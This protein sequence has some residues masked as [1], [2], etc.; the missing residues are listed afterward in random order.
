MI[1]EDVEV[2]DRSLVIVISL[3]LPEE[4]HGNEITG[5]PA[6]IRTVRLPNT[7]LH[8]YRCM[9]KLYKSSL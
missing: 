5:V 3:N 4:N 2:S 8:C 9:S 7:S 1:L 6:E